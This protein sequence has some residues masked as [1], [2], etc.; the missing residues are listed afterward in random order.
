MV[1]R[2]LRLD[3]SPHGSVPEK[4]KAT[5]DAHHHS[6]PT[7]SEEP[8]EKGDAAEGD[9]GNNRDKDVPGAKKLAEQ[10]GDGECDQKR[11]VQK[12]AYG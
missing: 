10:I 4:E 11:A 3:Y 12:V 7:V 9:Q 5:K 2:K 8:E 6:E 1:G